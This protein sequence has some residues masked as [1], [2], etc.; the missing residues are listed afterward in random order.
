MRFLQASDHAEDLSIHP[1]F[2]EHAPERLPSTDEPDPRA[3]WG[4]GGTA[5]APAE[6]TNASAASPCSPSTSGHINLEISILTSQ[7]AEI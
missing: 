3:N 6:T 4:G 7:Y 1:L 2:H 5:S